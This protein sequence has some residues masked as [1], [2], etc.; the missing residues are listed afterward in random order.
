MKV[1]GIPTLFTENAADFEALQEIQAWSSLEDSRM[2][3]A[4]VE[5]TGVG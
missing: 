5:V 2:E 1:G 3:E 4:S